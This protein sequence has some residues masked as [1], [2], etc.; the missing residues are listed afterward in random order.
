MN[1]HEELRAIIGKATSKLMSARENY[2]AGFM[3]DASSRAYYAAFHAVSAV[4]FADGKAFSSHKQ[5]LGAFNRDYIG[6]GL[7]PSE[8][9][10]LLTR[11]FENRQ[12]GDYSIIKRIAPD[13][14]YDDIHAAELILAACKKHLEG[15]CGLV[16]DSWV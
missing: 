15:R 14:A 5:T 2:A 11:L 8:F 1:H 6:P 10:R 7:F 9:S 3:D 13:A 16:P 4:L 12:M